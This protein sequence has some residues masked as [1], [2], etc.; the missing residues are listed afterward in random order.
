MDILDIVKQYAPKKVELPE[1]DINRKNDYG[2]CVEWGMKK[3]QRNE[4]EV[5]QKMIKELTNH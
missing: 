2:Y 3:A 1:F 5:Y 4:Y